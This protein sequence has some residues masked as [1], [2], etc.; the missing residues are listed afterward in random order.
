MRKF[1]SIASALVLSACST[2]Y[3][4]YK[5]GDEQHGEYGY[6]STYLAIAATAIIIGSANGGGGAYGGGGSDSNSDNDEY[7]Y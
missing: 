3:G 2:N 4:I 5:K 1:V 6:L 7:G